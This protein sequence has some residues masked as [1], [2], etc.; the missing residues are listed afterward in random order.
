MPAQPY[1]LPG[2]AAPG[3]RRG[4]RTRRSHRAG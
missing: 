1:P 3:A 4:R 2:P